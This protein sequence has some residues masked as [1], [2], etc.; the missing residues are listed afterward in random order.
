METEQIRELFQKYVPACIDF[1][2]EG[3]VMGE[4]TKPLMQTIPLTNLNMVRQLCN[5]LEAILCDK[6]QVHRPVVNTLQSCLESILHIKK[7]SCYLIKYNGV[8]SFF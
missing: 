2:L 1:V 4:L 7:Y 5:M 8:L 3:L 6:F